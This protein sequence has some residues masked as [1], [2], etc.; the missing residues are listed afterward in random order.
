RRR[1][2]R[3]HAGDRGARQAGGGQGEVADI[4]AA[5]RLAEGDGELHA[6]GVGRVGAG[7][8]D[9]QDGGR[10]PV[11]GVN[12]A[13]EEGAVAHGGAAEQVVGRVVDGVVV[14]QIQADGA[15]GR[16]GVDGD[17]VHAGRPGRRGDAGDRGRALG[18]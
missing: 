5:D 1:P 7:P 13:A 3:G 18:A 6:G 9:G 12:L 14:V 16:G 10:G 17:G 8:V 2:R 11:H 4:D 15:V